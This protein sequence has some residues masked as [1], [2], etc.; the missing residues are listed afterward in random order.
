MSYL[1]S[2]ARTHGGRLQR[3]Y[4]C[5]ARLGGGCSWREPR[6]SREMA[7][8]QPRDRRETAERWPRYSRDLDACSSLRRT[9]SARLPSSAS[10][11]AARIARS[12]ACT[13]A[14]DHPTSPE[15]TRDSPRFPEIPRE[16][17][18]LHR[19]L[20]LRLVQVHL[21]TA[22]GVKSAVHTSTS[23]SSKCTSSSSSSSSVAAAP[24]G[25]CAPA[26]GSGE[27]PVSTTRG[28]LH[29]QTGEGE[30]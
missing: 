10:A 24:L 27:T 30:G 12:S 9:R 3:S 23:A 2:I 29:T 21:F 20:H 26:A 28:R 5:R 16:E 4:S 6:D 19:R 25:E 8:R 13:A 17:R 11:S 22:V 15:I 14:R 7:E 18:R 1:R